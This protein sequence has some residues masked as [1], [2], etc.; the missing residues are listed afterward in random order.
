MTQGQ[1]LC[2]LPSVIAPG[3]LAVV[4]G[5]GLSG[6]AAARLLLDLG[7]KVRLLERNGAHIPPD[8]REE[9]APGDLEIVCGEHRSE[10]FAGARL[11]VPSPGVAAARIRCFL[12]KSDPPLL[13]AETEL[14]WRQLE[15]EKLLAVTGTSGKT[16]TT[17]LCAAMLERQGL[18]VFTG[19]NIGTPLSSYV[20]ARRAGAPKV[21]VV[22]LELS[23]FQLQT[24]SMLRPDVALLLNISPNHLDYHADMEE[25]VSAKMRLFATQGPQDVAVLHRSMDDLARFHGL[26]ARL[27]WHDMP[28]T[29]EELGRFAGIRLIGPHN[30]ANAQA[31]WLACRELGVDEGTASAAVAAFEP[32]EHRLE[33]VALHDDVLFVNDSKCTTVE[34]LRVALDAFDAPIL[35]LAGG[36]F[37]GGDLAA[38][39]PLLERKVRHMGLYGGSR[40]EFERAF[41]GAV[42]LHRDETL[43]QATRRLF[44]FAQRGD[45]MLLAPAAASFDQYENYLCRGDDFKR[46]V[47]L[48]IAESVHGA[49]R[50]DKGS[51]DAICR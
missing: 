11:V 12:P 14:A 39:R 30:L 43:E 46:V 21:D 22:V 27:V 40:E 16:T 19:G 33:R 7:A 10:D 35:L 23:S 18:R 32:L 44:T 45:V 20:L 2:S 24:C 9:V 6:L 13:M 48:L 3:E 5:A 42:P 28:A 26:R 25:Y 31:A 4:V 50:S 51:E 17:S 49:D 36:R 34:A 47:N 29:P 8:F 38:L 37:K 41:A 15:D 1:S